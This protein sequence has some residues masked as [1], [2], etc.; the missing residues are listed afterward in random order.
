MNTKKTKKS[1]PEEEKMS[2][3]DQEKTQIKSLAKQSTRKHQPAGGMS[4][5]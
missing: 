2:D 5:G 4:T 3:K 1:A